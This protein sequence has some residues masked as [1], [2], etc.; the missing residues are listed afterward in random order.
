[1]YNSQSYLY[2]QAQAGYRPPIVPTQM[3]Q[4]LALKGRP[5][6]SLDEARA[7]TIDF[8]GSVFYFP[9]LANKCIYTKQINIDGTATMNCYE[10]KPMP[11]P[12]SSDTANYITRDEFEQVIAQIKKAIPQPQIGPPTEPTQASTEPVPQF[13][14]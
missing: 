11:I 2:P 10:L 5:V 9:D 1:M 3:P 14:F 4:T 13:N 6:A 12:Q 8:D 7:S